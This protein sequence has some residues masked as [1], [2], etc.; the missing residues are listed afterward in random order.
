MN[1]LKEGI[2]ILDNDNEYINFISLAFILADP[3]CSASFFKSGEKLHV[4]ITPSNI[5]FREHII[6]T[7]L[8]AHRRLGI[9]IHF[10]SSLKIS[11]KISFYLETNIK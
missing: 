4:N 2:S 6:E 10:S 1:I 9:R 7:I 8:D 3:E 5:D 11:K